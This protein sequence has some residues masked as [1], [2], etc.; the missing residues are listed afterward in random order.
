MID[1]PLPR[2]AFPSVSP[3]WAPPTALQPTGSLSPWSTERR[4]SQCS[5][6]RLWRAKPGKMRREGRRVP[7]RGTADS[8]SESEKTPVT[9]EE[10]PERSALSL[11]ARHA[12]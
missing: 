10:P 2:T 1:C 6:C 12:H 7:Q 8:D 9:F 3:R 4:E 5:Q 11:C